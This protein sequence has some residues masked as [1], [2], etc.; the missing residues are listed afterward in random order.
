MAAEEDQASKS[1]FETVTVGDLGIRLVTGTGPVDGS[2]PRDTRLE[3]GDWSAKQERELAAYRKKN[4]KMSQ[5]AV[6]A[7]VL[8][9]FTLRWGE[10]DF[11]KM[12]MPARENVVGN[13]SA[14]DVFHA[15]CQLRCEAM[16]PD[17]DVKFDCPSCEE[18]IAWSLDVESIEV[19]VPR[20]T[21]TSLLTNVKLFKGIQYL[22]EK[23]FKVR[24]AP[25]RWMTHNALGEET[26]LDV[27]EVKLAVIEGTV[28]GVEGVEGEII[29]PQSSVDTLQKKDIEH[30]FK[31]ADDQ[32]VGPDLTLEIEC[33]HCGVKTDRPMRWEYDLFFSA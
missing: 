30:L 2:S 9:R 25:L 33:P 6:V 4:R 23:K 16:G 3:F 29:L 20:S 22:S 12:K 8:S 14:A 17:Y 10:H 1:P 19:T 18:Q 7:H 15:W 27:S 26:N 21:D 31:H 28:V 32:G 11:S 24:I 13:A 5:A